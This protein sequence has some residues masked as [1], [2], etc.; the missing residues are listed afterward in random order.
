MK[1][2]EEIINV[3]GGL[4]QLRTHPIKLIVGGFMPLCIEH[5]GTG[6]RGLPLISV[7]MYFEQNGDMMRDP[8]LV[9]EWD[10]PAGKWLQVSFRNDAVGVWHEAVEWDGTKLI[11]HAAL[12]A[13]LNEFA[14]SWSNDLRC[15]GFLDEA[16]R[17]AAK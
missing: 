5:I 13:D 14:A 8:D 10:V 1:T 3:L 12:V 9:M 4:N 17:T 7:A 15:Q 11:E 2:V 16:K 6:P